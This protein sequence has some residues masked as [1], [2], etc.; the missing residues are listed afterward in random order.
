MNLL[1]NHR[2]QSLLGLCIA[3]ILAICP[4]RIS[5]FRLN[6][7]VTG[8]VAPYGSTDLM[9][10]VARDLSSAITPCAEE[11]SGPRDPQLFR[12]TSMALGSTWDHCWNQRIKWRFLNSWIIDCNFLYTFILRYFVFSVHYESCDHTEIIKGRI[13]PLYNLWCDAWAVIW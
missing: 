4:L 12:I 1:H 6:E 10:G 7:P 5:F 13:A 3:P 11:R 8:L 9:S 2:H